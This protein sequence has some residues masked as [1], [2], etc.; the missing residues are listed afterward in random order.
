MAMLP[1]KGIPTD[2]ALPTSYKLPF[3]AVPATVAIMPVLVVTFRVR[4]F[5]KSVVYMLPGVSN[6]TLG[7]AINSA[8]V[9]R[10]MS[11]L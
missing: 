3:L 2:V 1:G 7:G 6:A 11:P 8:F 4:L 10:M 5:V 9:A